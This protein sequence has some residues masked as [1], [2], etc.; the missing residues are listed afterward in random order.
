MKDVKTKE[1]FVELRAHGL[2]FASIAGKLKV[3]KPTLIAWS[4]ELELEIRNLKAIEQEALAEKYR[5]QKQHRVE[6][7]GK[8]LGAVQK[9]LDARDLK[10]VPTMRLF[11]LLCTLSANAKQEDE[12]LVLAYRR[13]VADLKFSEV[14]QMSV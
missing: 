14:E 12:G 8:L 4:R 13:N 9:E 1:Q 10:Q 5:L 11:D 7:F 2:S 3:S 6:M